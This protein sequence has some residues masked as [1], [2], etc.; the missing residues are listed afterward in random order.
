MDDICP[1]LREMHE[2]AEGAVENNFFGHDTTCL[3]AIIPHNNLFSMGNQADL[4]LSHLCQPS[5]HRATYSLW[6]PV[7]WVSTGSCV[8]FGHGAMLTYQIMPSI[9]LCYQP[10]GIERSE[11][12]CLRLITDS[13]KTTVRLIDKPASQISFNIPPWLSY[14]ICW[15]WMG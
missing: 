11:W 3:L 14:H 13:N 10:K 8:L 5:N 15:C 6:A 4:L 12:M 1:N 9:P 7:P 2:P